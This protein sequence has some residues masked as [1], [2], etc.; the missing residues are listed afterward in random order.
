MPVGRT[1]S[2]DLTVGLMLDIEDTIGL[3]SPVDVP[4]VGTIGAEGLSTITKGT[5]F[6][7]EVSWLD[8]EIL[9]PR[10]NLAATAVT[11]DTYIIV[12]AGHQQR[13][14]TSD[15]LMI[16]DEYVRVTD[17]G[18]TTDSLVVTRAFSG[19]AI[20]H[21]NL[22]DVVGVGSANPEGA[23][24]QAA[25]TR[26]RTKRYNLTEIFGPYKVEVSGTEDVVRKYG[27]TTTEFDHQV[28]NRAMEANIAL[29]QAII[30]GARVDDTTNKW[31]TMGGLDYYI[32][33][34]VD[35]TTTDLTDTKLLD[36][37]ETTFG[38]GGNIN[39]VLL[40]AKQKRKVSGFSSTLIRYTGDDT[41]R[42]QIVDSFVS[43]FGVSTMILDRWV[44]SSDLFL[45][46]RDMVE[47]ATLRPLQFEMLAKTGDARKGQV[48]AEKTLK[49]RKQIQGAKFTALT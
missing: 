49:V 44:R 15:V 23:D 25:R 17:Y 5:C 30:Y 18:T 46:N 10:S 38:T 22:K 40:G 13:F 26:D 32:T 37:M 3:I 9:T 1:S 34:N 43:D 11:A 19:S 39:R 45:F 48:L 16:G 31:R 42:G 27:L 4:L 12:T 21:S 7:V 35:S 6:E 14:M 33:T 2:Y 24:P 47:L 28:A 29:E 41:Q 20:Q 36:Q 8:E